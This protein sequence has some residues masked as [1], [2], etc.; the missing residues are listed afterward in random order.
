MQS[1]TEMV[2][3]RS[4]M[5]ELIDLLGEFP[6]ERNRRQA[7]VFGI[8]LADLER[9]ART[10]GAACETVAAIQGVRVLFDLAELPPLPASKANS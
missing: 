7:E 8:R 5:V 4:L 6:S 3:P 1:P 9:R 10:Q 2:V